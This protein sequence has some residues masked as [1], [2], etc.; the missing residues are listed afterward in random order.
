MPET[1]LVILGPE[2]EE[3]PLKWNQ[4]SQSWVQTFAEA[5]KFDESI[6]CGP[7]PEETKCIVKLTKEYDIIGLY[8]IL[9]LPPLRNI[10]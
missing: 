7:L 1:F 4:D 6:L 2:H 3:E 9:F 8:S 5:T 10:L